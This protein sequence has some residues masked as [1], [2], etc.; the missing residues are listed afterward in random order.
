MPFWGPVIAGGIQAAGGL[1]GGLLG[2]SGQQQTNQAQIGLAREQMAF[3]ERMSNTA[4]QRGM[5]DMKAAGLNPILAYQLGGASSPMGA[6]PTLG[7]PAAAMQ[8]GIQEAAHSGKTAAEAYDKIEHARKATTEQDVN[9]ATVGL[10][11]ANEMKAQQETITS[12]AAAAREASTAR[13]LDQ[14]TLNAMITNQILG[15]DVGTA[16]ETAR[17]KQLEAEAAGQYGPGRHGQI[18]TTIERLAKT[19]YRNIEKPAGSP[20]PSPS[21]KLLRDTP[22]HWMHKP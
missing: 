9:K 19:L 15:H 17:L 11:K 13:N 10:V 3:Q 2:Q 21:P 1:L 5:A 18:L 12:A 6:M 7:N 16:R 20:Q 22:G 8:A 14:N 4:Y